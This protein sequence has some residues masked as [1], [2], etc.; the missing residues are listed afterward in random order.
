MKVNMFLTQKYES[1]TCVLVS[2]LLSKGN[3][4]AGHEPLVTCDQLDTEE[5]QGDMEMQ[6]SYLAVLQQT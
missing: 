6:Y 5:E 4:G 2:H 1:F 3:L